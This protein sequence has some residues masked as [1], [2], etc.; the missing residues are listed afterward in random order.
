MSNP[1]ATAAKAVHQVIYQ[2]RSLTEVL[3]SN[4]IA[5]LEPSQQSLVKDICFG[6]CRWHFDLN[7][8]IEHL[9]AKPLRQ[10]DKDIECL[11]RVGLYQLQ[12]QRTADHAA[13]NETVTATKALGKPWS[14]RLVNGVLRSFGRE[15]DVILKKIKPYTS[16]P[17]WLIKQVKQEWPQ[18][19][20]ELL[21]A[22]NAQ[23]PMV[24]RV[25]K[26]LTT[27]DEYQQA[28]LAKG[29][30]ADRHPVVES[31]LVLQ[32][33]ISVA[34]LPNFQKGWVSVQDGSAQLAAQFLDPQKGMRVLD[35]CAA[36]GGK[37]GH[38]AEWVNDLTIIALDSDEKRL[39]LVE[40]NMQ[41]LGKPV[42]LI[43]A[44][45]NKT[46]VWYDGQTFDRILLDAPCSALGVMRRHPDI[47]ILR[48]GEDIANLVKQQHDLLESLWPLLKSGGRLLYATCSI[49]PEENDH[50]I[51]QFIQD[52]ENELTII[53]LP[54]Q[55]V[56]IPKDVG[57][58]I[59]PQQN[60]MDGFYYALL[61][62]Q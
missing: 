4:A 30:E 57:I 25:N 42:Q 59:L 49:L 48:Q 17:H 45:A 18:E 32:S 20:R 12:Y 43:N 36:P 2:R 7:L 44:D 39:A 47:K 37:T 19:W 41:R 15:K 13:V 33:A 23:A 1:R 51:K 62:K 6:C 55:G 34:E 61:E 56:G 28:L 5:V 21:A 3:K 22:S 31:A 29:I 40:D 53:E 26:T 16:F 50:Q 54:W 14:K 8:M 38:L 60:N 52:H 24:L 58:Q 10:K 46:T 35:A 27:C 9:V 11:I